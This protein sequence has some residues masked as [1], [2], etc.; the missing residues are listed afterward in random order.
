MRPP[1]RKLE[2]RRDLAQ[3]REHEG[4]LGD[5]RMGN[6]QIAL[7]DPLVAVGQESISSVR[8]PQSSSALAASARSISRQSASSARAGNV[9]RHRRHVEKRRLIEFAPRRRAVDRGD[10][11]ELRPG[12]PPRR[13]SAR[14]K[15]PATSRRF[16]RGRARPRRRL[17]PLRSAS[18]TSDADRPATGDRRR[19]PRRP[20]TTADMDAGKFLRRRR[21]DVERGGL[22]ENARL[23]AKNLLRRRNDLAV[24]DGRLEIVARRRRGENRR[25][26]RVDLELWPCLRSWVKWP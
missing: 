3:R 7:V 12:V 19:R 11:R 2:A 20:G 16:R 17:D 18:K 24:V 8:G 10:A 23:A 22:D 9:S 13:P 5:A 1:G 26:G 6:L 25:R 14:T 21:R 15:A 4:A